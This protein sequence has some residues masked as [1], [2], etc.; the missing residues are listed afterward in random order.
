M[1]TV[2]AWLLVVIGGTAAL[3][4]AGIVWITVLWHLAALRQI[5]RDRP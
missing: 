1:R 5:D 4:A 3:L 2:L